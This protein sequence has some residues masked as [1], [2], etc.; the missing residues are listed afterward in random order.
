MKVRK[1]GCHFTSN[2]VLPDLSTPR[3]QAEVKHISMQIASL[4]F[5]DLTKPVTTWRFQPPLS[6]PPLPPHPLHGKQALF[7][8]KRAS[9]VAGIDPKTSAGWTH[10]LQ[11]SAAVSEDSAD[12][13]A[14][15]KPECFIPVCIVPWILLRMPYTGTLS[16]KQ[17]KS[18]SHVCGRY[19][20]NS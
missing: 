12:P 11:L 4:K 8:D 7:A 17:E 5:K 18:D 6:L 19:W 1:S 9:M 14:K 15:C 3:P 16:G 13:E 2:P 10:G 20:I